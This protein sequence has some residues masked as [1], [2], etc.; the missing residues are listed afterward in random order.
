[1]AT[2]HLSQEEQAQYDK[3]MGGSV[4]DRTQFLGKESNAY[5]KAT[6]M[7]PVTRDQMESHNK[8][9]HQLGADV[10]KSRYDEEKSRQLDLEALA[11]KR[12]K[13]VKILRRKI[14][15]ADMEDGGVS[16]TMDQEWD[17]S[18]WN[19][20]LIHAGCDALMMI[21]YGQGAAEDTLRKDRA[22][23]M[24]GKLIYRH[25]EAE[26]H[27]RKNIEAMLSRAT[28]RLIKGGRA[29]AMLDVH[30]VFSSLKENFTFELSHCNYNGRAFEML[31]QEARLAA[32]LIQD[33]FRAS[34]QRLRIKAAVMLP[35]HAG[36]GSHEE[37]H[38]EQLRLVARR[39]MD[40][41]A[42]WL[43]LHMF[44][45]K[46]IIQQH[47]GMRGP[48]QIGVN[49]TQEI[50]CI[51]AH[52]ISPTAGK[53]AHGNR[54]DIVRAH[55]CVMLT[56]FLANAQGP[57]CRETAYLLSYLAKVWEGFLPVVS[58]GCI[59]SA[60]RA[61][62]FLRTAHSIGDKGYKPKK[63]DRVSAQEAYLACLGMI[64][65]TAVHAAGIY[66]ACVGYRCVVPAHEEVERVDYAVVVG[67][68]LQT[69]GYT[70]LRLMDEVKAYLGY[71]V[72]LREL[73]AILC[74][75]ETA[76]VLVAA[77]RCL[78]TILCTEAHQKTVH[79]VC[80]LQGMLTSRLVTLLHMQ[81]AGVGNLALCVLLQMCTE[82]KSRQDMVRVRI[83]QMLLCR[84]Q[85]LRAKKKGGELLQ[86]ADPI[87]QR[88]MAVTAAL[89]RQS[90]WRY[91]DPQVL[92]AVLQGIVPLTNNNVML[93]PKDTA[94]AEAV[95]AGVSTTSTIG[96][97]FDEKA[98]RHTLYLD[99]LR[100][101][102]ISADISDDQA[103]SMSI[104]DW[105][106]V[107]NNDPCCMG[108]SKAAAKF[109][110]K[111]LVDFI[112]H[113]D[114]AN[115]YE[116]LPLEESSASCNLLEGLSADPAA[117]RAAF[118][119]GVVNFMSKYVYLLKYLFLGKTM[120]N[121]QIMVL[122]NGVSSAALALG[123]FADACKG[124]P[125]LVGE[126]V[127]VARHTELL[128]TVLFF[129]N[130]L[131][132]QHPK[133]GPETH[134]LQK[135]VGVGC[136]DFLNMYAGMVLTATAARQA[137]SVTSVSAYSRSAPVQAV[138]VADLYPAGLAVVNL[139]EYL[140]VVHRRSA[141]V[142]DIFDRACTFLCLL[143]G[144]KEG[145]MV[146]IEE[147]KVFDKLRV[148]LPSPL[149]G[150][151]PLEESKVVA[152]DASIASMDSLMQQAAEAR[153]LRLDEYRVGL[154]ALPRSFF[155]LC[156][157]LSLVDEGKAQCL[158][159]GFLRRCMDRLSLLNRQFIRNAAKY[160]RSS[161]SQEFQTLAADLCAC[162]HLVA[163]CANFHHPK[164]G[165]CND[166]IL[167]EL[168]E[169][170][171][172][173][174][175]VL[176]W[177]QVT[178]AP[179]TMEMVMW[180]YAALEAI[181]KDAYRVHKI[182]TAHDVFEIIRTELSLLETLPLAGARSAVNVLTFSCRGLTSKYVI[183]CTPRLREPLSKA[184]RIHPQLGPLVDDANWTLTKSAKMYRETVD[185]RFQP[186]VH[187]DAALDAALEEFVRTGSKSAHTNASFLVMSPPR[188]FQA[189][190]DSGDTG[191]AAALAD[192]TRR[193]DDSQ[194]SPHQS[195]AGSSKFLP[196]QYPPGEEQ[197]AG[198]Y[199]HCGVSSCGSLLLPHAPHS[200]GLTAQLTEAQ[201][202]HQLQHVATHDAEDSGKTLLGKLSARGSELQG[203]MEDGKTKG[204]LRDL[205]RHSQHPSPY[206]DSPDRT[207]PGYV[208]DPDVLDVMLAGV[209]QG[210]QGTQGTGPAS[211]PARVRSAAFSPSKG[212]AKRS[213]VSAVGTG[214]MGGMGG[215]G[216][217]SASPTG[218]L[219]SGS[220]LVPRADR[221]RS[222]SVQEMPQ[223]KFT[224]PPPAK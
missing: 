33:A 51:M 9:I 32:M 146:S 114:D 160:S 88:N 212:S 165:S 152:H 168:Y 135:A 209:M 141:I 147:W 177:Q 19:E 130:T 59:D 179:R 72:L 195:P 143:T 55:G 149:S 63:A 90:N 27:L 127:R 21:F 25:K 186:D 26:D 166:V 158:K 185:P 116:T 201:R 132:V 139:I 123:R 175:N 204:G 91:Y 199:L 39:S 144:T 174:K 83:D 75:T 112:C 101:M 157:H 78:F 120:Q 85:H 210:T 213:T 155:T 11:R 22:L 95:S 133:L 2:K 198:T 18:T 148:Y 36:F 106:V 29:T 154:M 208:S 110:A 222:I 93:R 76:V 24:L 183:D 20:E 71:D 218:S 94:M 54:E 10:L 56:T 156:A 182:F 163:N 86:Y 80:V 50:I 35:I 31:M 40:L 60:V 217:K 140:K 167:H 104:A 191:L 97:A 187:E 42:Q 15:V 190:S 211:L 159:D 46:S 180:A 164:H 192:I 65:Y 121:A 49:Y 170:V 131:S 70:Q 169:F 23:Q 203:R 173:L 37:V 3:M 145:G 129:V 87:L 57:F 89:C 12:I 105:V 172:L 13:V 219:S 124:E 34:R 108:M 171:P 45:K 67:Y 41:R 28:M 53:F 161:G 6:G 202:E 4:T 61:M 151:L 137:P 92:P 38:A 207:A 193:N 214:G 79:E 111:A 115:Y 206:P 66:R 194:F 150:I 223:L 14:R 142:V 184:A 103:E 100:T 119:P 107:P 125:A 48:I 58:T 181:A 216:L 134:E 82:H 68:L 102:R 16:I 64:T 138:A 8:F 128:T 176:C 7:A 188:S 99:L 118:S 215:M 189:P 205:R 109:G 84:D 113:P 153:R 96:S 126:Y 221:M 30:Y 5:R 73:S 196:T 122:L 69:P 117:A 77:L 136:L 17:T 43:S 162:L 178:Q 62:R 52:L 74:G 1:M 44:H 220:L 47:G 98:V 197:R 224:R 81:D 200:H